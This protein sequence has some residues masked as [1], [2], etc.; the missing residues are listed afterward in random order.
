MT[1][2]TA[3]LREQSLE[4]KPRLSTERA[5]LLT[6]F[7]ERAPAASVPVVRAMAFRHL[8][9][10]KTICINDGELIVGERG[11]APKS[12]PTYPELCCHSLQDLDIL[13][14]REGSA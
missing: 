3:R 6:D 2:R 8:L 11:T 13:N 4:T 10:H 1:D 14:T 12:T 9:E 7:Y 5:E